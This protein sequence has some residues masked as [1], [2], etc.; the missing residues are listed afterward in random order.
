MKKHTA[1]VHI[2]AGALLAPIIARAGR[3]HAEDLQVARFEYWEVIETADGSIAKGVIAVHEPGKSYRLATLDGGSRVIPE[4]DVVKITRELNP[5][6]HAL[7]PRAGFGAADD[8]R[9]PSG[10]SVL[11]RPFARSGLRA[12]A[13]LAFVFPT[14]DLAE[15]P[16]AFQTSPFETSFAPTLRVG[17]E[18]LFGNIGLTAGVATRFTYWVLDDDAVPNGT[19]TWLLEINAFGRGALHIGRA[20]PYL[21]LG[22]GTDIIYAASSAF[23]DT[24]VGLGM[25]VD[26]GLDI[27]AKPGLVLGL[28]ATY[29]PGLTDFPS[30][31]IGEDY[32]AMH[33]DTRLAF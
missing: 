12:S 5:H 3:A 13:E 28:G 25:N 14:G 8:D 19:A 27:H 2:I 22:I 15:D 33:L 1:F 23:D 32:W 20:A 26:F 17:H 21:G 29:H 6:Y 18:S 11:P 24:E 10:S 7:A 30:T 9:N 31:D 16:S 4:G